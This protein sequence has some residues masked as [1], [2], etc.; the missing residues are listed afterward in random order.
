VYSE[1]NTH[2][3][4]CGLTDGN[5]A[6]DQ[7]YRISENPWLVDFDLLRLHPLCCNFGMGNPSMFYPNNSQPTNNA[8]A[9]D[10]FLAATVAFGHP[11]FLLSGDADMQRSY[12]MVQQL[13]ARYTL[14]DAKDIRYLDAQGRAHETSDAVAS[15][16]FERSQVTVRY[17]DGTFVAANGSTN[18][19]MRVTLPDGDSLWLPPNGYFGYT[20]DGKVLTYSGLVDCHRVDYASSP[21]YIYFD[22]RGKSTTLP[23]VST[24]KVCVYLAEREDISKIPR[25]TPSDLAKRSAPAFCSFLRSTRERK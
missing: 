14:A 1:G 19:A 24:N 16:V 6:Q 22:A 15:G 7:N 10:R 17:S 9:T 12:F 5:Y 3:M 13:A 11:G 23:G 4:Y 8:L 2:F 21:E 20:G 25:P 18:E